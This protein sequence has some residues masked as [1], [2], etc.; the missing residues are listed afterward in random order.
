MLSA[1]GI[2]VYLVWWH[3]CNVQCFVYWHCAGYEV[4]QLSSCTGSQYLP[5][6][7][8]VQYSTYSAL[9]TVFFPPQALH[10]SL[11]CT[12][13]TLSLSHTYQ[14]LWAPFHRLL[15]HIHLG[16]N[17]NIYMNV[18]IMD[19]L[20]LERGDPLAHFEYRTSS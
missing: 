17:C 6:H 11:L 9:V 16:S 4:E 20:W 15:S 13:G 10:L 18:T 5:V 3:F 1:T 8:I 19:L 12:S 14:T 2:I 7:T